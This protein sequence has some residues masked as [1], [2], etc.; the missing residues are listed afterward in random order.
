MSERRLTDYIEHMLEAA[1]L[2]CLYIE[3]MRKEDF[4]ADKRTQQA[5]IMNLV[6]I[7][8]SAIK[9][10]QDHMNFLEMYP[11]VPSKEMKG[12][13]NRI[14]HGYFEINLDVVWETMQSALPDLLVRLPAI[15]DKAV[16]IGIDAP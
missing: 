14:A 4:V 16:A 11:E 10:L 5:V 6:I 9:L 8:E 7:G 1:R 12:M 15:R 2:A 13:R 3:G